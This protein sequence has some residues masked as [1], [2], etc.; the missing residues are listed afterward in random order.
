MMCILLT[1]CI[2]EMCWWSWSICPTAIVGIIYYCTRIGLS[3]QKTGRG[4]AGD[5]TGGVARGR[6][7]IILHQ[8]SHNDVTG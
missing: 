6:K 5:T 2:H 8:M 1:L 4:R 7:T 3:V